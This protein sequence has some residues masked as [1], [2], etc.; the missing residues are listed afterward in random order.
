MSTVAGLRPPAVSTQSEAWITTRALSHVLVL[1]FG[2][3][4]AVMFVVLFVFGGWEYYRAPLGE[5]GYLPQHQWLRP[6][7]RVGL[8]LGIAGVVAMLGTLPYAVR[9]RWKRRLSWP[10]T[11]RGVPILLRLMVPF[12]VALSVRCH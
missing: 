2:F 12:T 10:A 5:R 11:R 4:T 1:A 8:S 3:L 6:S 7:G 9:K